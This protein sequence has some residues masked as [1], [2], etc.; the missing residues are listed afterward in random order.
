MAWVAC[1]LLPSA[2]STLLSPQGRSLQLGIKY[3]TL[4]CP[5]MLSYWA[6]DSSWLCENS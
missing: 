5:V 1:G 6:R 4:S 3:N 2:F